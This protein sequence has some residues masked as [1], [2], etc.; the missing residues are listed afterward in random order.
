MK[1]QIIKQTF[2]K[3]WVWWFLG[4]CI[5]AIN[6]F[7]YIPLFAKPDGGVA[8]LDAY[9]NQNIGSNGIMGLT[10]IAIL[11]ANIFVT[12]EVDRGTLAVTL[13]APVSRRE[14]ILSKLLIFVALLASASLICGVLGSAVPLIF[15]YD[16]IHVKWWAIVG[17][18]FMYSLLL[19]GIAF[20][21]GCWFNKTRYTLGIT[22]LIF[23]AFYLFG[24][25]GAQDDFSVLKYFTLQSL[26]DM[27][28]VLRGESVVLQII[29]MPIIA[30][31]CYIIGVVK[32]LKKDLPL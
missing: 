7:A 30:I 1:L 15:G 25:L 32:F 28:A 23:L 9:A 17:L 13:C 24:M 22:A 16:F 29:V 2:A 26:M 19:G 12:S 6:F 11:F 21:I 5:M 10:V 18:Y 20:L 3:G 8:L 14:I 31:P 4:L 27:S